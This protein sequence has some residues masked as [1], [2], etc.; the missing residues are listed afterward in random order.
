M[1]DGKEG[2]TGPAPDY[3]K[4]LPTNSGNIVSNTVGAATEVGTKAFTKGGVFA[5][6]FQTVTGLNAYETEKVEPAYKLL[7]PE[8]MISDSALSSLK[9]GQHQE[10]TRGVAAEEVTQSRFTFINGDEWLRVLQKQTEEIHGDTNLSFLK[11]RYVAVGMNEEHLTYGDLDTY[12]R[13][14]STEMFVGTHELTAPEEFEWK[15]LERGFSAMVLDMKLFGL[16]FF[17]GSA[18]IGKWDLDTKEVKTKLHEMHEH[19]TAQRAAIS[20]LLTRVGGHLEATLHGN[21]LI[22]LGLDL[23]F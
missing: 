6:A 15:Q 3:S 5:K 9:S 16:G 23:P 11:S 21:P 4:P 20:A 8:G 12:V 13:G 14:S 2:S 18:D 7:S 1:A 10:V 17:V 19:L 22:S